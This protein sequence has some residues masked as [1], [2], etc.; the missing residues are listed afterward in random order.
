[1]FFFFS[2]WNPTELDKAHNTTWAHVL[3]S[4]PPWPVDQSNGLSEAALSKLKRLELL[5][6]L[7]VLGR[8]LIIGQFPL[9]DSSLMEER[10]NSTFSPDQYNEDV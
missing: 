6:S 5:S 4:V 3:S 1:M 9:S 7:M 10:G 8:F 2:N